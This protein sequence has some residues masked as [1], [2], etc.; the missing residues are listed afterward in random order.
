MYAVVSR[1]EGAAGSVESGPASIASPEIIT[2]SKLERAEGTVRLR[3]A[4]D[5]ERSRLDRCYQR[6]SMKARFP[7]QHDTPVPEAVL[8]NTAGGITGGDRFSVT[9]ELD[10]GAALTLTSQAAERVYRSSGGDGHVDVSL[11]LGSGSKLAWLPQETILFDGGRVTRTL[12]AV[13]EADAA[14]VLCESVIL[15][16]AAH[17]E[18]VREGLLRDRWRVRRGGRLVYADNLTLDFPDL[19]G[20]GGAAT[21]GAA[22]LA[23]GR[24]FASLLIVAPSAE[25]LVDAARAALDKCPV[26]SGASAWDGMLAIRLVASDGMALRTSIMTLVMATATRLPRAWSI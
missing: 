6:G 7:R 25:G 5:G 11:T 9:A 1:Y 22:T 2:P 26:T 19:G 10:A 8:L 18:T 17:G 16:R 15:G 14:L 3:F 13:M 4:A 21:D 23:G 20:G 12:D 24:A